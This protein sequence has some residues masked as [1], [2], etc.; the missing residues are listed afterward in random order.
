[1]DPRDPSQRPSIFTKP[2]PIEERP[3]PRQEEPSDFWRDSPIPRRPLDSERVAQ[4][5]PSRPLV[6]GLGVGGVTLLIVGGLV[7]G[8]L[9]GPPDDA[10]GASS[11]SVTPST[12]ATAS[13]D[14][15]PTPQPSATA[16]PTPE[17]TP[18]GPPQEVPVGAWATV[19]VAELNVRSAPGTESTSNYLLVRGSVVHV[20]E[21]PTVVADLNWYR[22]ASLGGA[23]GWVT[24]GWVA[25]PFMAT[26][27]ED[28]TLIR[29][30]EVGRAVFDVVNGAPTPHDPIAIGELALPAAAFSAESLA[31]MEL[32][33]GVGG[34]ACFSAQVGSDGVPVISAQLQ[35]G[36]CGHA[37]ADGD[38]FRL[39]PAASLDVP[40]E[41]LVKDP[42]IVHPTVLVGA[43]GD[44][45]ASNM[46]AVLT[47]M[48]S[49]SDATGCVHLTVTEEADGVEAYRSAYAS[50]CSIVTEY[51]ADNIRF[52][53]AAGGDIV[54]IKLSSGQSAP[55]A[56]PLGEAVAV[57]VNVSNY[58][59]QSD[60][61][62]YQAYEVICG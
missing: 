31:A 14:P 47:M 1:M 9:L 23:V 46:R 27:V 39:R 6:I 37:V 7:A 19:T 16:A 4:S 13:I 12:T 38:F 57:A 51:N 44:R 3:A 15:T 11:P 61:Y 18:A 55:D 24:S 49:G 33:R 54:W 2:E 62:A 58:E 41:S 60:A 25:E 50:Q 21:G 42:V 35:V 8:A 5:G 36:A 20:A 56:F 29:C 52:R 48:A 22:I 30:G 26:L 59:E 40:A 53:P 17:P 10:I 32:L 43:A 45:Q 28:P 34:E